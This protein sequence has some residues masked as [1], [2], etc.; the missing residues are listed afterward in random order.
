MSMVKRCINYTQATSFTERGYRSIYVT[1]VLDCMATTLARAADE[2]DADVSI[3]R[4]KILVGEMCY[5]TVNS[6]RT[7]FNGLSIAA[8]GFL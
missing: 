6:W 8:Q 5:F 1:H 4:N 3:W 7:R 2:M